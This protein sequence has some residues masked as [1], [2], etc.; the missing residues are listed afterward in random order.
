MHRYTIF[1]ITVNALRVSGGFSAVLIYF[2]G[3]TWN[4][5]R[6][7]YLEFYK[8]QTAGLTE[9][10]NFLGIEYIF[11]KKTCY[12]PTEAH[13]RDCSCQPGNLFFSTW[14]HT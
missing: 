5:E 14:V 1:F 8:Y 6:Y 9:Q 2:A 11:V 4:H 3:E 7:T 13:F 10:T 12:G